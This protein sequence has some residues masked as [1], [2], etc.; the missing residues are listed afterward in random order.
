MAEID[1]NDDDLNCPPQIDECS[2]IVIIGRSFSGK[3]YLL[4]QLL[5]E[6][7][8]HFSFKV[9]KLLYVYRHVD[10]NVKELQKKLDVPKEFFQGIPDDLES[11][12][13]K[14]SILV[15]D[16]QETLLADNK[17]SASIVRNFCLYGCHHAEVCVFIVQQSTEIMYAKHRLH[18]CLLQSTSLVLFRSVNNYSII[19]R[20]LNNFDIRLDDCPDLYSLY[21]KYVSAPY[22]Y[23]WINTSPKLAKPVVYNHVLDSDHNNMQIF[24]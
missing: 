9:S 6:H 3:S 18:S 7:R 24:T 22:D 23:L 14:H 19:K 8:S 2:M 1:G 13:L 21:K 10:D 12:V 11:K 17:E 5:L 16:D 20:Y 15:L 4:R